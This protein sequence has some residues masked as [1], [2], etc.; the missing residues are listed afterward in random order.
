M[1]LVS[2]KIPPPLIGRLDTFVDPK[3][4]NYGRVRLWG[5]AKKFCLG[6]GVPLWVVKVRRVEEDDHFRRVL[7][8]FLKAQPLIPTQ[9]R[10]VH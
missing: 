10:N 9:G 7:A 2:T 8:Y 6:L 5:E 1:S 4:P 3:G